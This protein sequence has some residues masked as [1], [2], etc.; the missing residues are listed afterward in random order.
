MIPLQAVSA[1][2]LYRII[3]GQIAGRIRAGEFAAGDRLPSERDLA[4][5]LQV[6]R[7]SVREALIALEL[8][9]Y[10]EVRVGTGVFV[11]P[12]QTGARPSPKLVQPSTDMG[13]DI[14]PFD[15]LETRLL[16]EPESA[17]LAAQVALPAQIAAIEAAHR[18]MNTIEEPGRHDRAFHLAIATS[19]GNAALA[20][21][22]AH[23][24]SLSQGS[25]VYSRM[26]AHFVTQ[27]IWE[28]A[29]LEHE[30]ILDAIA[31]RDAGRARH[32]MHDHLVGILARLRADFGRAS[33]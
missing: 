19:C 20:S 13:G 1:P 15:L 12:A 25:A 14:G 27:H 7:A 9:G 18:A 31:D 8:E 26:E 3:A 23:L 17:A 21:A 29:R 4:E 5:H 32:A 11:M 2:R 16:L 22:I 30:Q 10:V 33:L 6:S 28:Q 24:W